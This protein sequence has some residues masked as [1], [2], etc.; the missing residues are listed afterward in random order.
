MNVRSTSS[1]FAS[2]YTSIPPSELPITTK[3]K[4]AVYEAFQRMKDEFHAR[5]LLASAIVI[6]TALVALAVTGTL[7]TPPGWI[8]TAAVVTVVA[9]ALLY[10]HTQSFTLSPRD[11][12]TAAVSFKNGSLLKKNT[13]DRYYAMARAAHAIK[14]ENKTIKEATDSIEDYSFHEYELKELEAFHDRLVD[15]K[16]NPLMIFLKDQIESDPK[17]TELSKAISLINRYQT[18]KVTIQAT[19]IPPEDGTPTVDLIFSDKDSTNIK[20]IEGETEIDSLFK[21]CGSK[22]DVE[23]VL[24]DNHIPQYVSRCLPQAICSLST[25]ELSELHPTI[26]F[27][28]PKRSIINMTLEKIDSE[29]RLHL[30]FEIKFFKVNDGKIDIPGT[31]LIV[32]N[33]TIPS[34]PPSS[35]EGTYN[36]TITLQTTLKRVLQNN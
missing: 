33:I 10:R 9:G 22:E 14:H 23:R 2:S 6:G 30:K 16:E 24:N 4:T 20:Y 29:Y 18:S 13:N 5:P 7:A 32:S 27:N 11:L 36:P 17:N 8:I 3:I 25:R 19:L 31:Y 35:E 34:P 12:D 28:R 15:C 21:G 1:S 26:S